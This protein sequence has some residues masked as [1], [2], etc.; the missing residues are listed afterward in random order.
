M[1]RRDAVTHCCEPPHRSRVRPDD[2]TRVR[3]VLQNR[4]ALR[5][6]L[7][8]GISLCRLESL[9][10]L[11][12]PADRSKHLPL[13]HERKGCDRLAAV[14]SP[15]REKQRIL[16]ALERERRNPHRF[17]QT[18]RGTDWIV[19]IDRNGKGGGCRAGSV[20]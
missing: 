20:S 8:Q 16:G 11:E 10:L 17:P 13:V 19:S 6:G 9:R 4:E 12:A 5:G 3:I 15:D 1:I 2:A 14:R 7:R 18:K